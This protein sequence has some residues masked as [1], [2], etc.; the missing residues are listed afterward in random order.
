MVK[1]NIIFL[2]MPGSG[3]GTLSS[4]LE[5]RTHIIQVSTGD[6][7]REEIQKQSELGIKVKQLVESGAY[8]PDDITNEIVKN[9]ILSLEKQNKKF[10]LDGFPRTIQQA[11]FLDELNF[12]DYVVIYLD[13]DE[14]VIIKRL[15]ER[16]FCPTCK[17]SYNLSSF[18]SKKHPHCENDDTLLIQRAD[19]Q[20]NAVK[21]RLD[22]YNEQ[23]KPLIDFYKNKHKL[24]SIHT[25]G[26][27]DE[28]VNKILDIIM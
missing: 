26:E 13:I 28:L 5:K 25:H 15:S 12:Q 7:F 11:K 24:H 8:V 20:P 16:F 19:D 14:E 23:T 17:K 27:I 2:G 21:K 9:K 18:R 4:I 1:T 6:I 22:V 3:K 10:I